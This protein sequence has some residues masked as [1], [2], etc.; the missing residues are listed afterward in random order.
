M[1]RIKS[2]AICLLLLPFLAKAQDPAIAGIVPDKSPISVNEAT[3]VAADF[4]NGSSTAFSASDAV[5]WT[6]HLGPS[7]EYQGTYTLDDATGLSLVDVT[8]STYNASTGTD[9]FI[10]TKAGVAFPGGTD[11]GG[12]NTIYLNVKGKLLTT[13]RDNMT[14]GVASNPSV[15]TNNTGNDITGSFIEVIGILPLKLASLDA[16]A[17]VCDA[18]LG[19]VTMSEDGVSHF[20]VEFSTDANSFAK[21]GSVEAKHNT[22]GGHYSFRYGQAGTQGYYRL[23][24]V[25]IDGEFTYSDTIIVKTTSCT[26]AI[27]LYP[28]PSH[29]FIKMVGLKEGQQIVVA[30]NNGAAIR[31]LNSTGVSLQI[32]LQGYAAGSYIIQVVEGGKVIS[33]HRFIKQ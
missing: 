14:I 25:D 29:D 22:T 13:A 31:K 32:S 15:S 26:S 10:T 4:F 21:V 17:E 33:S 27:S 16:K 18:V 3:I 1:N 20:D 9:I 24:M 6:I 7:V 11:P 19:W 23:K 8:A 2:T 5:T 28:N 30:D 12:A